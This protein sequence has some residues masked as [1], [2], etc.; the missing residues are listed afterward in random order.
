MCLSFQRVAASLV[1]SPS[2][3]GVGVVNI[4]WKAGE[5]EHADELCAEPDNTPQAGMPKTPRFEHRVEGH[6]RQE[7]IRARVRDVVANDTNPEGEC[8]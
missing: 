3:L 5:T 6:N 4:Q 8:R 1:V 2:T 7:P